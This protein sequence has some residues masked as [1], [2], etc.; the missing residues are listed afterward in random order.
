MATKLHLYLARMRKTRRPPPVVRWWLRWRKPAQAGH[1][2]PE[3]LLTL[4]ILAQLCIV[5]VT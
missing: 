2:S 1:A 5:H 4:L 3:L